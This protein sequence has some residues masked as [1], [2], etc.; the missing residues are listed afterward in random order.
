MLSEVRS[1]VAAHDLDL[2][3][4]LV[5]HHEREAHQAWHG[6][7][8]VLHPEGLCNHTAPVIHDAGHTVP[9]TVHS[10]FSLPENVTSIL[11]LWPLLLLFSCLIPLPLPQ[12]Y[13]I[14]MS[15]TMH[16]LSTW[17]LTK[18]SDNKYWF[19]I[20]Y[21]KQN[22]IYNPCQLAGIKVLLVNWISN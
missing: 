18:L 14:P 11:I 21:Y 9:A 16:P 13:F 15:T 6:G 12:S 8:G 20:I 19:K 10:L 22:V 2:Y 17:L 7:L 5:V 1:L 4:R 3:D